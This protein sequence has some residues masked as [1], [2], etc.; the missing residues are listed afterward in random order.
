VQRFL[1][2]I[3]ILIAVITVPAL[4]NLGF[5]FYYRKT[6]SP[7]GDLPRFM[8]WAW[9]H[10]EDL[11][12]LKEDEAAAAILMARIYVE[13][14]DEVRI[15]RRKEAVLINPKTPLVAAV[16]IETRNARWIPP[17]R[18]KVFEALKR[19]FGDSVLK[20][21]QIDFEAAQIERADY[22][23][24]LGDLY[25]E[26]PKRLPISITAPPSWCLD[27]IWI[28]ALPIEEAVPILFRDG[29]GAPEL[30]RLIESGEDPEESY[31]R[32]ALGVSTAEPI[33]P[34]DWFGRVYLY[35]PSPWTR[36]AFD[37]AIEPFN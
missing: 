4:L 37:K 25:R 11:R 9:D 2:G 5:E 12:F 27:D 20:A 21:V 3:L 18:E 15:E 7:L 26:L 24:L 19:I 8:L 16:R 13:G 31:C 1:R 6:G 23:V 14:E 33:K 29:P 30:R 36:E 34:K 32:G 35:S 17:Q 28:G 22:S 10:P